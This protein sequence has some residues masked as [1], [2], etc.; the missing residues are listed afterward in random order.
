[1]IL[2]ASVFSVGRPPRGNSIPAGRRNA[3][4]LLWPNSNPRRRRSR[5]VSPV[6]LG[7]AARLHFN[8]TKQAAAPSLPQLTRVLAA[9]KPDL[10]RAPVPS[11]SSWLPRS[12]SR[13]LQVYMCQCVATGSGARGTPARPNF[14]PPIGTKAASLRIKVASWGTKVV[15]SCTKVASSAPKK[16]IYAPKLHYRA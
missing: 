10:V 1:M 3:R 14:D 13:A 7:A 6:M 11:A 12:P 9:T 4:R 2:G 5:L 8:S 15:P 16:L